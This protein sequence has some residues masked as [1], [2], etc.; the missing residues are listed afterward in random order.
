M[1]QEGLSRDAA[2]ERLRARF[3]AELRDVSAR[4]NVVLAR[5]DRKDVPAVCRFLKDEL[6]FDHLSCISA[7]DLKDRF[8]VVY[9]ISSYPNRL[10][11]QLN[12]ELPRENPSVASVSDLW[13]GANY[14]ER[15]AFD[16]M[17]IVFEGHPDL[18]R[19]LLPD[20]FQGHP[21]RKDFKLAHREG[22]K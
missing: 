8:E 22:G 13:Y 5:L 17:G 3:P 4:R 21:L 19:I 1:A 11:V 15:E 16:M 12:A 2:A 10:M 18:K 6:G 20:D 14:H 7:V 9:H